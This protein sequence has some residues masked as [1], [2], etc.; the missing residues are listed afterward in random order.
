L[1]RAI[2]AR[3]VISLRATANSFRDSRLALIGIFLMQFLFRHA[4]FARRD[5]FLHAAAN[6]LLD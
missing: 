2:S 5:T 4:T 6:F 1:R 3:W